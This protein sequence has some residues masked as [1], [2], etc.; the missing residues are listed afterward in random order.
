MI[1][2]HGSIKKL[3]HFPK[4]AVVQNLPYGIDT[5]GFWFTSNAD[6]AKPFAI[7]T[8]TVIQKSDTEFWEDGEPKVV[9]I[10]RPVRGFVYKVYMDEPNLKEYKSEDSFDLF[11]KERDKYCDY[12]TAGKKN[13]TWKDKATL[14]NKDE[15]NTAV[16]HHLMKM[17]YEGIVIRDTKLDNGITDMYCIFSGDSL[18]IAEVIPLDD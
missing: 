12:F 16:R 9:Q 8:E 15:A 3:D 18:Y 1:I 7:G 6:S 5:I 2:Y 17:G 4:K 14:L 13:P 10:E 11:M